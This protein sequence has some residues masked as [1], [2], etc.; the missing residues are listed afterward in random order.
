MNTQKRAPL[1]EI[2]GPRDAIF[3]IILEMKASNAHIYRNYDAFTEPSPTYCQ[4]PEVASSDQ[5]LQI[6]HFH[7]DS[8]FTELRKFKGKLSSLIYNTQL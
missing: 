7:F 2:P 8:Q 1:W 6:L 5:S 3:I 4:K